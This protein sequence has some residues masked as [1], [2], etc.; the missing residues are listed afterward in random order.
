[1]TTTSLAAASFLPPVFSAGRLP[2]CTHDRRVYLRRRPSH[3][4][5]ERPPNRLLGGFAASPF[6]GMARTVRAQQVP[7]RKDIP[8]RGSRAARSFPDILP[9][10][11]EPN[12]LRP[13]C[14]VRVR[15]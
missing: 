10:P 14:S 11:G 2:A 4:G 6:P 12:N 1:M 9:V 8:P 7:T 3:R 5:I 13:R 15:E